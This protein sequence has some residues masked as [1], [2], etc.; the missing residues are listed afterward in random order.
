MYISK[1]LEFN[2]DDCE[3]DVYVSDGTF[4]IMCY[5]YPVDEICLGQEINAVFSYGCKD[6]VREDENTF[7]VKKLPQYYAYLITAQVLSRKE[8][9]VQIGKMSI[10][11]DNTMPADI[12]DGDFVTFSVVRFEF[13]LK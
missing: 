11:L 1:I 13:S 7:R 8:S 6:I 4:S 12:S 2:K 5:A 9:Y 3:A 10:Q